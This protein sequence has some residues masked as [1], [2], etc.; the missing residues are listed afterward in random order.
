MTLEI[1]RMLVEEISEIQNV[2]VQVPTRAHMG[3]PAREETK[4]K[5]S[6]GMRDC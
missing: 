2:S 1:V 6:H 3:V 4:E 5:S